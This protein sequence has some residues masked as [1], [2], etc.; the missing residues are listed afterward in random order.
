MAEQ[1]V[2]CNF[3]MSSLTKVF[4][5]DANWDIY[6]NNEGKLYSIGKAERRGTDARNMDTMYGDRNHVRRLIDRGYFDSTPTE[7]GLELMSGLQS[8]I[9]KP[10]R[11]KPFHML[12][13]GD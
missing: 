12:R 11:G 1:L 5:G 10:S 2:N 7:A 3:D 8:V 6:A 4:I 9:I 13:F